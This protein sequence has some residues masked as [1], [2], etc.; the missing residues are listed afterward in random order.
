M[1]FILFRKHRLPSMWVNCVLCSSLPIIA[2]TGLRF[3]NCNT[4]PKY[5]VCL[6]VYN[7]LSLQRCVTVFNRVLMATILFFLCLYVCLFTIHLFCFVLLSS[8]IEWKREKAHSTFQ[9]LLRRLCA[10]WHELFCGCFVS[11]F[12]LL[13]FRNIGIL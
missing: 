7:G 10:A 11:C 4:C 5:N 12:F 9:S 1:L 13:L 2:I 6:C 8:I 3:V